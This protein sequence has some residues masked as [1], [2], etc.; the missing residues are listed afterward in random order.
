MSNQNPWAETRDENIEFFRGW[1]TGV[2]TTPMSTY[3]VVMAAAA[4]PRPVAPSVPRPE[5]VMFSSA[6]DPRLKPRIEPLFPPKPKK[7]KRQP[8]AFVVYIGDR[9]KGKM[10]SVKSATF[11]P[12]D[13]F[14]PLAFLEQMDSIHCAAVRRFQKAAYDLCIPQGLFLALLSA[15]VVWAAGHTGNDALIAAAF[16]GFFYGLMLFGLFLL[17]IRLAFG[18]L[19]WAVKIV[20]CLVAAVI[21]IVFIGT[22]VPGAIISW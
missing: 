18:A 11:V 8:P 16:G 20:V 1:C 5:P 3:G 6:P 7:P 21:R 15:T 12:R 9:V 17:L 22:R 4:A 13:R 10:E 19:V 14:V 2:G